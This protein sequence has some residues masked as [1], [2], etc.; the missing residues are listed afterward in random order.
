MNTIDINNPVKLVNPLPGE[1]YLI[2][3]I[4]NFNE[5]TERC[6]IELINDLPGINKELAPQELVSLNDLVN[7]E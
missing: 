3:K 4:T 7:V 2:F 6:Y 5:V 1:E